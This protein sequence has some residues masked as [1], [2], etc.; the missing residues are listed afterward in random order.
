MVHINEDK[1]IEI[2]T[3]KSYEKMYDEIISAMGGMER[4]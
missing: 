2:L 1:G 4:T 3:R